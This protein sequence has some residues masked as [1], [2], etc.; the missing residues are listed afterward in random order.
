[1]RGS[2]LIVSLVL[3]LT[4]IASAH[5]DIG[6]FFRLAQPIPLEVLHKAATPALKSADLLRQIA[7]TKE[8]TDAYNLH[9]IV[10]ES[11]RNKDYSCRLLAANEH[12]RDRLNNAMVEVNT[13]RP[14]DTTR[15]DSRVEILDEWGSCQSCF[16][17][18]ISKI[19]TTLD[20][21]E[22]Q[23][24][25]AFENCHSDPPLS[26]TESLLED[27]ELSTCAKNATTT[28]LELRNI[29]A[30]INTIRPIG[31]PQRNKKELSLI[32]ID[33]VKRP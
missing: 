8:C 6:D 22:L 13:V 28:G 17:R 24:N 30:V 7:A 1:M 31:D 32:F 9:L 5:G 20:D 2:I 3:S 10:D 15:E 33:L 16:D 27:S 25:E 26:A 12:I 23:Y 14:G 4:L 11:H 21:V 18:L 19:Q 29:C